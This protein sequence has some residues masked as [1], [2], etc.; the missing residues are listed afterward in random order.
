MEPR[1][2]D[3]LVKFH[4]SNYAACLRLLDEVKDDLLLDMYLA[5]HVNSLYLMIRNRGLV[6][7]CI[8]PLYMGIGP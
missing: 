7:V 2:N 6:Q 3:I 1:L 8:E 4:E 5:P